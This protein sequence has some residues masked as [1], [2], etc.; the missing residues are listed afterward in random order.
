MTCSVDLRSTSGCDMAVPAMPERER[1]RSYSFTGKMPVP[2]PCAMAILAMPEH[3]QDGG[4]TTEWLKTTPPLSRLPLLI[5][6]QELH[7]A[8]R[9]SIAPKALHIHGFSFAWEHDFL[10]HF[11]KCSLKNSKILPS[12]AVRGESPSKPCFCPGCRCSSYG[13]LRH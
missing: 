4:D 12:L 13:L 6:G 1:S 11:S 5:Q 7:C 9:A 3:D 2:R 10:P 8:R